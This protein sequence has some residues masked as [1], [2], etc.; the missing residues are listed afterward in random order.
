MT[1]LTIAATILAVGAAFGT[2]RLATTPVLASVSQ[3]AAQPQ[4]HQEHHPTAA[5][6]A[7]LQ[8]Q[9]RQMM[10]M[11][12]QMM[13]DMKTMDDRLTTLVATMKSATGDTKVD[14]I[15]ELVAAIVEQRGTMRD[16]MM[17]MHGQ[18]MGHM[19]QHM[20][21]GMTPEMQKMMAACP[22]MNMIKMMG[23]GN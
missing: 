20:S 7:D 10:Q 13:A 14:A 18:M 11:H 6:Q 4:D 19:M 23:G 22:M 2:A 21:G 15:A 17:G 8:E 1:R 3:A 12:Q 5:Q 9:E 16:R